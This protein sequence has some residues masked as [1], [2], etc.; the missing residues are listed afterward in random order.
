MKKFLLLGLMLLGLGGIISVKAEKLSLSFKTEFYCAANWSSSTNTFTW[1]L[2]G[3]NSAWTFMAVKDLSGDL[4][5]YTKLHLKLTEFSNSVDNKLTLYFKENKGNTQSMDYVAAVN[6]VPDNNG[7]VEIDLTTFDWK[8]QKTPTETID[9][10]NIVDVTIYGGARTNDSENGSVKVTDAYFEK[11]DPA[12]HEVYSLAT[13]ITFEQVLAS[14]E[15]YVLVQN[16]KVFC[17]SGNDITYKDVSEIEEC[18]WTVKFEAD[19]DNA[20][21]YYMRFYDA[22]NNAKGYVNASVWSHTWLSGVDKNG[23]KGEQQDGALWTIEQLPNGKYAIRNVGDVEGSYGEDHTSQGYLAITT[24][25][26]WAN[27]V[28]HYNTS[29]EWEF[30]TLGTT[31]LTANDP[32]YLGWDNLT[33]HDEAT[34]DDDN[35]LVVDNRSY[36]PYWAESAKWSFD[37]PF[38]ATDYRYLVFYAKRNVTKFGNG[39][40]ETGGTL[41]IKDAADVTFRQDDLNKYNDINYPDD[42]IGR[43][44]MNR[45]NEQRA[46]VL[47]LQWLANTDKY[48][49]G[50]EC[51]VLDITKIKEIGVAGT[52]TIGGIFFTN[53]LPSYSAGDYKR[54]YDS[55]NKFGTICLPYGAVCCGAQLYEIVSKNST[56]I[57]LAEYEGVMEPGKPYLYKSLEAKK[58][59]MND[60]VEVYF[61]KAGYAKEK[62]A[63]INNG[64][65]GSF[66]KGVVPKG[67]DYYVVGRKE[68]DTEDKIFQV[69]SDVELPANRAY[70]DVSLIETKTA[71]ARTILVNFDGEENEAT[72]IKSTEAAEVVTDAVFY[73]MS[74]R[75]VKNPTP[76]IY[77]VKYGNKT[78][79]VMIK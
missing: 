40:N 20:N 71:S 54:G 74:G 55:F 66:T 9:K 2:G 1:G 13:P 70:I 59:D 8:N 49:D 24:S 38:D 34:R 50:S 75:E 32:F 60:E 18:A 43:L 63:G 48:G 64:L 46:T 21:H 69:D 78:K 76:G 35:H 45:W 26:Y 61:F 7:V 65:V 33:V 3:Y 44:W 22:S 72:A 68:G 12:T 5:E 37:T 19:D 77:I 57:T 30:Y 10:T 47:D 16:G 14:T 58:G 27:H 29:G 39:D 31:S 52:F 56:G 51:K 79:K 53:T 42:H 73:D 25:G 41:F 36:A 23:T 11:P 4:S 6:L 15:P 17:L 67:K 28:T 62:V